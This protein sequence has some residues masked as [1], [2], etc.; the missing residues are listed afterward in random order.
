MKAG[1]SSD[2]ALIR[3]V[4]VNDG[5]KSLKKIN[6]NSG[7]SLKCDVKN[8]TYEPWT[9]REFG[10]NSKKQLV[11]KGDKVEECLVVQT[12]SK[13]VNSFKIVDSLSEDFKVRQS[14]GSAGFSFYSK[15]VLVINPDTNPELIDLD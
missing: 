1:K 10:I 4:S 12:N 8:V 9:N 6:S 2:F 13:E 5:L 15:S 11:L 14:K 3:G 7:F